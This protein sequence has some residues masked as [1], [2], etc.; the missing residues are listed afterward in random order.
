MANNERE[1]STVGEIHQST[2]DL[3][4]ALCNPIHQVY[5]RAGLIAARE[6]LARFV[7]AQDPGIAQSIRANWWP[8]V[9]ADHGPPRQLEWSEL[10]ANEE[11]F[12]HRGPDVVTPTLEALPVALAFLAQ[13]HITLEEAET[14]P[15]RVPAQTE[16]PTE[17]GE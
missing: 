5:F 12:E 7:E 11:P 8:R 15:L 3:Q 4:A 16:P 17:G 1:F 13:Q 10:V 14:M 2:V 9:G 6:S